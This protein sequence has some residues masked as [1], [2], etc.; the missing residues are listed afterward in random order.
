MVMWGFITVEEINTYPRE[1]EA[2][3]KREGLQNP[4]NSG[5]NETEP[6]ILKLLAPLKKG[7]RNGSRSG[8]GDRGRIERD[9]S[10]SENAAS[11]FKQE[12]RSPTLSL[13]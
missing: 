11:V 5:G 13:K 8:N 10:A 1:D 9:G 4:S 7:E 6:G 3:T 2:K 12:T